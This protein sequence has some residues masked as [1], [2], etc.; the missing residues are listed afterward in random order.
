MEFSGKNLQLEKK[1]MCWESIFE[2][3][4]ATD[5][6]FPRR[7]TSVYARVI[8][9]GGSESFVMEICTYSQLRIM[10]Q[11]W[12]KI[13]GRCYDVNAYNRS[14]REIIL[15]TP[16]VN[17]RHSM[18]VCLSSFPLAIVHVWPALVA[19]L[20]CFHSLTYCLWICFEMTCVE[21]C[22]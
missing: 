20:W 2:S 14:D 10:K 1:F 13:W 21:R 4:V 12:K 5:E 15:T 3:L 9:T 19:S 16:E 17:Y 11:N 6:L 18:S 8:H 7:L 22:S